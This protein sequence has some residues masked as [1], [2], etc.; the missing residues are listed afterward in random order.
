MGV[1]WD[2]IVAFWGIAVLV[3]GFFSVD[4]LIKIQAKLE[5]IESRIR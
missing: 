2:I 4:Y 3:L 1:I 5:D